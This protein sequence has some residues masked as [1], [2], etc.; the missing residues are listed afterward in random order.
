MGPELP[1]SSRRGIFV[2][3][4]E[5]GLLTALRWREQRV[6]GMKADPSKIK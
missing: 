5:V 1:P 2:T 3:G 4:T 6:R